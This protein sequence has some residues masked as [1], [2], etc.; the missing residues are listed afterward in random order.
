MRV[1]SNGGYKPGTN[2]V[3][4]DVTRDRAEIVV[5]AHY[6]IVVTT[7]PD[8]ASAI[9]GCADFA[10]GERLDQVDTGLKRSVARQLEEPVQV[11]RHHDESH[12]IEQPH[13]VLEL[14]RFDQQSCIPKVREYTGIVKATSGYVVD[15]VL[16]GIS[17]FAKGFVA[18]Q[19]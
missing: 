12:R 3:R 10:R 17:V 18:R 19:K 16:L 9:A 6:T 11:V 1:V 7:L 15:K 5:Q 13:V 2:R 4:N 8:L 14:Q